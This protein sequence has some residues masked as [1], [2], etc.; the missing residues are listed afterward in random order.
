MTRAQLK[1][2]AKG[3]ISKNYWFVIGVTFLFNLI[4]AAVSGLPWLSAVA[5]FFIMPIDMGLIITYLDLAD[6]LKPNVGE[7]FSN[8][9]DGKYYLRRVGGMAWMA[10]FTFLWSLLFVIPGIVKGISYSM[11]PYIL[12]KYPEIPAKEA[13]KLS[14]KVMEGRKWEFF[15][16]E[17]SF[18]GWGILAGITFGL[19]G[20]FYVIPYMYITEVLWQQNVM[21]EVTENG[22]FVYTASAENQA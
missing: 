5:I 3:I 17:L 21:K 22:T 11:T 13:L 9:F 14:M 1:E 6:G 19:L 4:I 18:I 8:G 2:Q 20:I 16:L 15:V 12:A 7:M 10:L